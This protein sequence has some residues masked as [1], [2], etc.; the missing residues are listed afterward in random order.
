[1]T[2]FQKMIA[3]LNMR[4]VDLV[5]APTARPQSINCRCVM[6]P[7]IYKLYTIRYSYN[8]LKKIIKIQ[9]LDV[10]NAIYKFKTFDWVSNSHLLISITRSSAL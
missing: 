6:T 3:S 5:V 4:E 10:E 8:G 2:E 7:I 1:M 9:A